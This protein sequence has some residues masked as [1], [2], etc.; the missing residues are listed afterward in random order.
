VTKIPGLDDFREGFWDGLLPPEF[1]AT[2]G[3]SE[4]RRD[5]QEEA[6]RDLF[7]TF[8]TPAGRR[9][10]ERARQQIA[11][12]PGFDPSLGLLNGIAAGFAREGQRA[13]VERWAKI[14]ETYE[15]RQKKQRKPKGRK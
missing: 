3:E 10:L 6:A 13:L 12:E 5:E 14:V 2:P 15:D 8:S 1:R 9:T 7:E 4:E 11:R